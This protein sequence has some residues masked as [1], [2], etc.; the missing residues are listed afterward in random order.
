M[1]PPSQSS[2]SESTQ[3]ASPPGISGMLNYSEF[4]HNNN[5][6]APLAQSSLPWHLAH[7]WVESL[8]HDVISMASRIPGP[9]PAPEM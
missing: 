5:T 7:F 8:R 3:P 2:R 4:H 1:T 6:H 9:Y